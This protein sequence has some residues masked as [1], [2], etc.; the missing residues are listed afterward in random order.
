MKAK[1]L[2]IVGPTA[3]GKTELT[4]RIALLVKNKMNMAPEIISADSRQL[5]RDIPIAA[6]QPPT[7]YLKNIKHHFINK[8][9]LTE[10]YN[11]G[12]F[13]EEAGNL[14]KEIQDKGNIPIIAGG[15]GLYLRALIYGLFD[16]DDDESE[17]KKDEVR[18]KLNSR[19]ESE[20]SEVLY[21]EL[22]DVDS[23]TAGKFDST[24]SRRIIRA[25]E[26]YYL[27]G[28]PIS[29]WHEKKVDV[30]FDAVQYGINWERA[31]LYQRI[32]NRV[33]EMLG[34]GLLNE[35]EA[36]KKKGFHY[37]KNNSLNTVG[38][39]EAFDF[40]ERK[41]S[42]DEMTGLI[43]RNTRRYAKRQMT[44]FRKDKNIMWIDVKDMEEF[45]KLPWKIFNEFWRN[46]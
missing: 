28:T 29:R 4:Y 12:K 44:W 24:K 8:L 9:E 31:A 34:K 41:I 26:V 39:K 13:G 1:V 19:L 3:S 22:Q 23:V 42:E 33:D 45:K 20:G 14:I 11:A 5:Y 10:E 17:L 18:R 37:S 32:N 36:L 6:A 46:I 7:D 25:L 35:V 30:G 16:L 15:S 40:L 43:K 21:R 38:I 27:T 2:A